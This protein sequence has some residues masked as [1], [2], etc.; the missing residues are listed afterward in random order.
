LKFLGHGE[1][2]SFLI[3]CA[4]FSFKNKGAH[5]SDH[6]PLAYVSQ[7]YFFFSVFEK[8]VWLQTDVIYKS[9]AK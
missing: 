7:K 3:N 9:K 1:M 5:F 6:L 8:K 4:D 2:L